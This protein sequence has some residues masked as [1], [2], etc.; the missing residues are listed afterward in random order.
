MDFLLHHMLRNS[1]SRMPDK[2]ALVY[3]QDRLTYAEI[4]ARADALAAGLAE[5]GLRR[6]ERVGIYL[7]PSSAP[8]VAIFG[9]SQA[10]GVFV[11]IHSLLLPDQVLHIAG[12]CAIAALVTTSTRLESLLPVLSLLPS[13]RFLVVVNDGI[14]VDCTLPIYDFDSLV[15]DNN[16]STSPADRGIGKD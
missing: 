11:P 8:A 13:L 3:A 15:M 7:D 6:G 5:A 16:G 14:E 9:I 10:G 12:D 1:A 2:E 4:S